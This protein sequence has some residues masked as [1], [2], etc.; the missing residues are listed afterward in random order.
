VSPV[1]GPGPG[2]RMI[3]ISPRAC[4]ASALTRSSSAYIGSRVLYRPAR[5]VALRKA[6]VMI[7]CQSDDVVP[8]V[9]PA[10]TNVFAIHGMRGFIALQGSSTVAGG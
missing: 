1:V 4:L 9:H 5:L 10:V 6:A 8:V 7:S 3:Q 2:A